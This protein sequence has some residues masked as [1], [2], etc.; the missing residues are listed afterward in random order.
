MFQNKYAFIKNNLV[1]NIAV[2]DDNTLLPHFKDVYE[3]DDIVLCNEN[4]NAAVGGTYD[5]LKFW[6]PQPYPSWIKNQEKN[7]WEAPIPYPE[8]E[9]GSDEK[10]V[11]D[12]NSTSWLLLPPSN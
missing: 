3:L 5:G 7:E 11:W 9:D 6:L 2:F 1:V 12:E 10:Y 8:I 4:Y